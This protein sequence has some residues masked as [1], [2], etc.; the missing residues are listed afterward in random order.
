MTP[1]DTVAAF[2]SLLA[3]W[4]D[5]FCAAEG[6]D[7]SSLFA[8]QEAWRSD[9]VE[10]FLRSLNL[11]ESIGDGRFRWRRGHGAIGLFWHGSRSRIPRPVILARETIATMGAVADLHE[12]LHWPEQMIEVET[13]DYAFDFAAYSG[14]PDG[15]EQMTIA[16]EAKRSVRE[17]NAW[18]GALMRCIAMGEHALDEHAKG[19]QDAGRLRN[20]HKKRDALIR[21][22]PRYL[23]LVAVGG[24]RAFAVSYE[25]TDMV[26]DE[27]GSSPP[28]DF[29][30]LGAGRTLPTTREHDTK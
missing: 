7:S 26:L 13:A 17:A 6:L 8:H 19:S 5:K 4:L 1:K 21:S 30:S 14:D 24:R 11:F 10:P 27:V 16:G 23:W 9:D 28:L 18:L 20:A 25:G 29:R 15:T 2:E 3:G 12:R 22:H